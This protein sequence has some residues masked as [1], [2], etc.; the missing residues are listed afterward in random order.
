LYKYK[1]NNDDYVKSRKQLKM[2]NNSFVGN[3]NAPGVAQGHEND[4][5]NEQ[6]VNPGAIRKSTTQGLLNALSNASGTQFQSVEDALA[7]MAR[8]GAQSTSG[9]SAQPVVEQK[10]Q[11][12]SGRV[13]TNDLHERFNEL[14][15]NLARKEQALRERDLD[16]D[17]Q[18]SMGDRFDSDLMDYALSKVKSNIQWNQ[19]GTYAI[20]NQ[21]GQERYGSDGMPLT[22]QGLVQEVAQGNPKLLKQ[23]NANSGSGLRPGQGQFTGA[24]D[25]AVPDYS[26]DPA[27]FNAWANKN[28]LGKGVGLKGLTVSASVSNSSRKVL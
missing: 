13:T 21:K 4:N 10:V 25:E 28:G 8:V 19:D 17:I 16:S 14:Q 26:R 23:S 27:A 3:D 11:N 1:V 20:V 9:G 5:S 24:M 6:N 7:F 18:R 12:N 22:I 2:D 15:T